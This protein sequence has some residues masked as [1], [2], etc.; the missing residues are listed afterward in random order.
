MN[1]RG[2]HDKAEI[3]AKGLVRL[4]RQNEPQIRIPQATSTG[5]IEA[6]RTV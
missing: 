2:S 1:L 6:S 3:P 4:N 5:F